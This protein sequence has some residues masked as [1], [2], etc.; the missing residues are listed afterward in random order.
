LLKPTTIQH[1]SGQNKNLNLNL[2]DRVK[3]SR[4]NTSNNYSNIFSGRTHKQ[5]S[6]PYTDKSVRVNTTAIFN[7]QNS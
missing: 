2:Y 5:V 4:Q 7:T 1:F 3:N 6:S